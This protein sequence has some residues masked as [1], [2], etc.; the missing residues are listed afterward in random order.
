MS[1]N[2]LQAVTREEKIL[3]AMATNSS[4]EDLKA[5]TRK[6][7]ILKEMAKNGVGGGGVS[8]STGI[9]EGS[10]YYKHLN[11][12]LVTDF[13][14]DE[15]SKKYKKLIDIEWESG[16]LS[17]ADG[18][19]KPSDEKVRTKKFKVQG[20]LYLRTDLPLSSQA[21]ID[22]FEYDENDRF[23]KNIGAQCVHGE[24]TMFFDFN[25]SHYYRIAS[26]TLN[27][28][29]FRFYTNKI[30][31]DEIELSVGTINDAGKP[32]KVGTHF[33][34][35]L[36]SSSNFLKI[37]SDYKMNITLFKYD[38]NDTFIDKQS[39]SSQ[40]IIFALNSD[41][42]YR[43]LIL[44][45]NNITID[46]IDIKLIE[47]SDGGY[48]T[49]RL[50]TA[51][52]DSITEQ[53]KWEPLV[54]KELG[55]RCINKGSGGTYVADASYE[56]PTKYSFSADERINTIDVNS[57]L[58]TIMGGTND[59]GMK[60][61]GDL[62]YPFDTTKFKGAL[63]E[64]VRKMQ[65]RCPNAVIVVM[66][67]VGGRGTGTGAEGTVPLTDSRGLT[68]FDFAK[69]SEEV[70]RFM[71]VYFIDVWSCGINCFNRT[72]YIADA[73]HPNDEGGKLIARKV[74]EGL[75]NIKY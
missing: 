24:L 6:E 17:G 13:L 25:E 40:E 51:Y 21:I 72:K 34:T 47:S 35:N 12:N 20:G 33:V 41:Y 69:A 18:S 42:K 43:V 74:I 70:A 45:S 15:I 61:L 71:G 54:T 56:S 37:K 7:K 50:W 28:S 75:K 32:S 16:T 38:S 39:N 30:K 66:S 44:S 9:G 60:E 64:T 26:R 19:L 62:S 22:V 2:K 57:E 55:L 31:D 53:Y 1:N 8:Q 48:W 68:P 23:I 10:I 63:A 49:G 3:K 65:I 5:T 11:T 14:T 29:S 58:V 27:V 52:G 4:V 59:W 67:N 46:K 36:F 73:V